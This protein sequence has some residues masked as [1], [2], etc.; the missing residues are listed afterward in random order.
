MR[1]LFP[2]TLNLLFL[3]LLSISS[4]RILLRN[5]LPIL[6]PTLF[7]HALLTQLLIGSTHAPTPCLSKEDAFAK[8]GSIMPP[9]HSTGNTQTLYNLQR[10]AV[11]E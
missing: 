4:L 6:L 8:F 9:Q 2:L 1:S 11:Q 10:P 5:L 7:F 3:P